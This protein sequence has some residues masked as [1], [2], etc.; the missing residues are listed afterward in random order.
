VAKKSLVDIFKLGWET[1]LHQEQ[2]FLTN[3]RKLD[4]LDMAWQKTRTLCSNALEKH[5]S[6]RWP[7]DKDEPPSLTGLSRLAES[8]S[9]YSFK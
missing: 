3:K 1:Y 6:W 2:G 5:K 7:D 4:K 9:I 8:P